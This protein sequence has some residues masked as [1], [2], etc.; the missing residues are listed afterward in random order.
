MSYGPY[1]ARNTP[2]VAQVGL[3]TLPANIRIKT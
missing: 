1:V 2:D 3:G